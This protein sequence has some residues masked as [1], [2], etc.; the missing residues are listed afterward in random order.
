MIKEYKEFNDPIAIGT[1][2]FFY[3]VIVIILL[4]V[5]FGTLYTIPAG[6]KGVLLTFNKPSEVAKGEGLHFKIPIVQSVVKMDTR[7]IKYEADLT[8]ASKDLQDVSTKIAINYHLSPDNVVEVYRGIGIDYASKIIYPLEQ[9]SNKAATA[10]FVAG[11]LITKR[12][13]VKSNM[14]TLLR[15]KLSPRG[16]VVESISIIDFKFSP[17][18]SQAIEAKVTAEQNALAAKNK[19][20]QV[21]YEA[22]QRISQA[23]GEAEAIKIQAQAIQSQGGKDY[24]ELQRIAKWNGAYPSV[25]GASSPIIDMRTIAGGY[26]SN[27][28]P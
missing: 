3:G 6:Y 5:I 17:S 9:E 1:K 7:T 25:V 16:I 8:A 28:T 2:I 15:E 13:E 19:L 26:S 10:Q 24:V 14:E 18:F 21:K 27:S 23:N 11:E 22:E 12:E 20:E 4:T